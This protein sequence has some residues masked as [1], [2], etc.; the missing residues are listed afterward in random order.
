MSDVDREIILLR[1]LEGLSNDE[2]A[3]LLEI[4][5]EAAKKRY[6][7]ALLRLHKLLKERGIRESQL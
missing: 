2:A 4:A 6:T 3:Y 5:P 1:T 7:R